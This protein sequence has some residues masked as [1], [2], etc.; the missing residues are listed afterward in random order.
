MSLTFEDVW[1]KARLEL[2]AVPP[3]LL[4]S[5]A[6]DGYARLCDTWGWAFL[7]SEGTLVTAASRSVTASFTFGSASVTS[8]AAFLST[9][10][11]RQIRVGRLPVYTIISV[12]STSLLTLDRAYTEVDAANTTATIQDCYATMPADFRRFLA[13]YDRYY[14]R[15][16]PFWLSEDQLAVADPGRLISDQGPRY[17]VAQKYSPATATAGQVRYEYWPA[18]TAVRSYPY[19]YIRKAEQLADTDPLPG[20]V[21]ERADLLRTYVL[22]RGARWAGTVDQRNPAYDLKNAMLLQNEWDMEMQK[23]EL[24]DD[25]EY[26]QQ[27]L[28]VDWAKRMGVMTGTASLLRQTDATINDYY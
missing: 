18:P 11:G 10:A 2:P 3:L 12:T 9:D 1:R 8:A 28:Q 17:L 5:W 25:N 21:S 14:Q 22:G 26:P 19:L 16:I 7:R 20:V 15:I 24:A 23:L 27:L 6:Q 4:R 13:V